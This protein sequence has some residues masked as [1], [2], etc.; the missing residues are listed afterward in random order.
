MVVTVTKLHCLLHILQSMSVTEKTEGEEHYYVKLKKNSW[1]VNLGHFYGILIALSTELIKNYH[2][3][4]SVRT[5]F[6]LS[7][8]WRHRVKFQGF[9]Y[10]SP[11][12]PKK[13]ACKLFFSVTIY[14][15]LVSKCRWN[16]VMKYQSQ[17]IC[18]WWMDACIN[19]VWKC[20]ENGE[21]RLDRDLQLLTLRWTYILLVEDMSWDKDDQYCF[22][23]RSLTW[24]R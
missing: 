16:G 22:W 17:L 7:Q 23:D 24:L 20:R 5:F 8:K 14:A 1:I 2:G 10:C 9:L 12:Q 6:T 13:N 21:K 18:S 15:Y 3:H 19:V 4:V 11:R